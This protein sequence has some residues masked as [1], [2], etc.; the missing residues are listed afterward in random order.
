MVSRRYRVGVSVR[1]VTR[2]RQS[3]ER[4]PARLPGAPRV[5]LT[6]AADTLQRT[7]TQY[8]TTTFGLVEPAVRD[9]LGGFLSHPE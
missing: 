9:G 3:P 1:L 2:C 4:P 7:L 6:V 8:L 5:K